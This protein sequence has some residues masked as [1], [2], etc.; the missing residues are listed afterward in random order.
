MRQPVGSKPQVIPAGSFDPKTPG[1]FAATPEVLDT[2]QR[3]KD[4]HGLEVKIKPLPEGRKQ[5]LEAKLTRSFV[6][7]IIMMWY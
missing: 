6:K 1:R 3:I 7:K 2:I 4:K 5:R